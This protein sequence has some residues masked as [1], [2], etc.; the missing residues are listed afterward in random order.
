MSLDNPILQAKQRKTSVYGTASAV[1]TDLGKS[2]RPLSQNRKNPFAKK[3]SITDD[4]SPTTPTPRGLAA[5]DQTKITQTKSNTG[6]SK[7]NTK[8]KATKQPTLFGMKKAAAKDITPPTQELSSE[9]QDPLTSPAQPPKTG[10][11]LWFDQNKSQLKQDNPE[12]ND[13]ELVRLGAQKFKSLSEEERQVVFHS[14]VFI[15]NCV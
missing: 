7:E 2:I 9:S 12:C 1:P 5:F 8:A 14:S 6:P 13:A 15:G 11:T 10:F 3:T 4:S